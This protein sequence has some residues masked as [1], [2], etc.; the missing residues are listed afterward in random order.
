[1]KQTFY[2]FQ[3]RILGKYIVN[4]N[5]LNIYIYIKSINKNFN[6]YI[7]NVLFK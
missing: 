5:I 7:N 2:Q 4:K 6:L 1:M 3:M